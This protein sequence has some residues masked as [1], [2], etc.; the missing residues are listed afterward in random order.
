MRVVIDT[1]VVVSAFTRGDKNALEIIDMAIDGR[2]EA[3]GSFKTKQEA[4]RLGQRFGIRKE[5]WLKVDR[6]LY[7]TREVVPQ[8]RFSI[9]TDRSDNLYFEAAHA[10]GAQFIITND[11]HLLEHD[12]YW[13]IRVLRPRDF[14]E[15][16]NKKSDAQT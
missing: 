9:S 14:L 6:L 7:R 11:H 4:A 10:G 16:Q 5:D 2:L 12:G 1:N 13:G 3:V 15:I 8:T